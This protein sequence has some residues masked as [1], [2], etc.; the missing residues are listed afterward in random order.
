[1][2]TFREVTLHIRR[3]KGD[4]EQFTYAIVR[5][6]KTN[7]LLV[8]ATAQYVSEIVKERGYHIVDLEVE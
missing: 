5:D 8:S 3:G 7:E 2:S 4:R 6:A 1:M